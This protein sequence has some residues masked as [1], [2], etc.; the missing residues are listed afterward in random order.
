MC[1]CV[2]DKLFRPPYFFFLYFYALL[3]PLGTDLHC[4]IWCL[5]QREKNIHVNFSSHPVYWT[6]AE[7]KQGKQCGATLHFSACMA[8]M[9]ITV[10]LFGIEIPE[11]AHLSFHNHDCSYWARWS[12]SG[13]WVQLW[14]KWKC[15]LF[16]WRLQFLYELFKNI[17]IA[18]IQLYCLLMLSDLLLKVISYFVLVLFV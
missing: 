14:Q 13:H 9:M 5:S 7:S 3:S 12:L 11:M 10:F 1:L 15:N 17:D 16:L 6:C 18:C 8:S 4:L 2:H